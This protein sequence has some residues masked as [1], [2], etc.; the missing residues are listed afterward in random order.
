MHNTNERLMKDMGILR[1]MQKPYQSFV[2][3]LLSHL[4]NVERGEKEKEKESDL[5]LAVRIALPTLN[6]MKYFRWVGETPTK[7]PN[8]TLVGKGTE[9]SY[10]YRKYRACMLDLAHMAALRFLGSV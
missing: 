6:V 10:P 8:S 3:A 5:Y 9:I 1:E 7:R 4:G 2:N